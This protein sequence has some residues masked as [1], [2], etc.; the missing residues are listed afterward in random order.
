MNENSAGALCSKNLLFWHWNPSRRQM[1]PGVLCLTRRA[2]KDGDSGG[3]AAHSES[4]WAGESGGRG[5][6]GGPGSYSGGLFFSRPPHAGSLAAVLRPPIDALAV[7]P[8][9]PMRCDALVMLAL[10]S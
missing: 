7:F 4:A 6:D 3:A 9:N 2:W 5:M 1:V 10:A 8:R